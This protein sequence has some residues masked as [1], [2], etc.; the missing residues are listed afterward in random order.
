MGEKLCPKCGSENYGETYVSRI[1]SNEPVRIANYCRD[2]GHES[3]VGG[4]KR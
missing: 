4:E 3:K 1:G 2:C